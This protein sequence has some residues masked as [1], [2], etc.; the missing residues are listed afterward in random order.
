MTNLK[1]NVSVYVEMV[2]TTNAPV[3]VWFV[4]ENRKDAK[5][6]VYQKKGKF[7]VNFEDNE[8]NVVH[9]HK[10]RTYTAMCEYLDLLFENVLLDND[11]Y[12]PIQRVQWDV[13]GFTATIVNVDVM[14]NNHVYE[15][16]ARCIDFYFTNL[17]E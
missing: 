14:D 15:T 8:S 1:Q 11:Y 9:S 5:L 6:S 17:K 10:F 4:G 12:T 16:F 3:Y 2:N 7:Y 13:P